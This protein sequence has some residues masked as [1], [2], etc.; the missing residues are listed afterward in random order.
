MW[1]FQQRVA[2]LVLVGSLKSGRLI[3]NYWIQL[4]EATSNRPF[5]NNSQYWRHYIR[6]IWYQDKFSLLRQAYQLMRYCYETTDH[7][8]FDSSPNSQIWSRILWND[9]LVLIGSTTYQ[10][11]EE[12]VRHKFFQLARNL[13]ECV[14]FLTAR[15]VPLFVVVK[16]VATGHLARQVAEQGH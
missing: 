7:S 1:P 4:S 11:V 10:A 3:A 9:Y 13:H 16:H 2:D 12:S 8:L 5:K 14:H 6:H 15:R